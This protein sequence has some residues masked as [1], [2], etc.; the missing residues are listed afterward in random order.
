MTSAKQGNV[1]DLVR[2]PQTIPREEHSV[3]RNHISE[4]ALKVLYRLH[5][6]GYEAY[7]VGG[8]VRDLL[9]GV[10]PKDFDVVTNAH[11]E[12]V[13]E[14]FRNS[15]IIGRRFRLV[16]VRYGKEIIEVSTFR[17]P[18]HVSDLGDTHTEDGRILR[19]NVYGEID[20]DVWR[21]DFTSNALFYN[22]ADFSIVDYVNG[23]ADIEA[24]QICLIG[25]PLQRYVED[26]VR[27]LRAVR[28]SVKLGFKIHP[29]TEEP[30]KDNAYLL[31]DI[32]PARLFEESLKLFMSGQAFETLHAL[33][34]HD[35]F[36]YLFPL[37]DELFSN[38]PNSNDTRL[39]ELACK[40]TDKR[41][42]EDKPVTP[43]FLLAAMLWGAMREQAKVSMSHSMYEMDAIHLA[44]DTVFSKQVTASAFP[45]RL[46]RIAKEVW[47][48]QPRLKKGVGRKN[49]R[50]LSHPRFRA[51]Y[52][53]LLLR[54]ESGE[55]VQEQIEWWTEKQN[56]F[57]EMLEKRD[58]D[59][60][61]TPRAK[62]RNPKR[63]RRKPQD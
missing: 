51:A 61:N 47:E 38:N 25:D 7:L 24:K 53:F 36:K 10:V 63:R 62:R 57:P 39:I 27:M 14:L 19:D 49:L 44:A 35:L 59:R 21:R 37:A 4:S 48:L 16:H 2:K 29:K 18:H 52:D 60:K 11:P 54:G 58:G 33:R 26:P 9:L 12:Q 46:T 15:R 40:N 3:S 20:D 22:I 23:L 45:R 41:I 43:G 30:I 17:A 42:A 50:L 1:I 5:N 28:F 8:A 13:R 31:D 55:D 34:I 32:S 6:A 56:E